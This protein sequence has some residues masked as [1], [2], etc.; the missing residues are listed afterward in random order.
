MKI[1]TTIIA[2][3][4]VGSIALYLHLPPLPQRQALMQISPT[5]L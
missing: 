5:T 1:G 4:G 3:L 2:A